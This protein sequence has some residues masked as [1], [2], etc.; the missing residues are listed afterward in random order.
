MFE[1]CGKTVHETG[2]RQIIEKYDSALGGVHFK[3]ET[4]TEEGA[5]YLD[6]GTPLEHVEK[7]KMTITFTRDDYGNVIVC[8]GDVIYTLER[9]SK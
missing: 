2:E 8:R 4:S 1:W 9:S 7:P 5:E 3:Y 6:R